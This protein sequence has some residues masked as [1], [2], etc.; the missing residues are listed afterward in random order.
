VKQRTLDVL[1]ETRYEYAAPVELAQHLAYLRPLQDD[2]QHVER[3]ALAIGPEPS[4]QLGS[5]DVFRN[6]RDFFSFY[7]PHSELVVIGQSRVKVTARFG[8]VDLESTDNWNDVEQALRYRAGMKFH[9]EAQFAF[10]SPYV[11]LHREL[12]DYARE[13]FTP[14]RPIGAAAFELMRRIYNDFDYQAASTDISTPLLAAFREK[15]G[16]CQDFAHILISCVRGLGLAARYVSGYLL[17]HSPEDSA[18]YIGA[19][20]SHAWCSVHCPGLGVNDD[21]LD[22]DPTNDMMPAAGHVTLARG[23]DYGDVTPLRGVIRGGGEH[24]LSVAVST[25]MVNP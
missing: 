2:F 3:H 23:R 11:A 20:A 12:T 13:S 10:A 6:H 19:D 25:T 18:N 24:Q 17:T 16:V 1:H 4:W 5:R 22:L 7:T 21:W 9:S 8:G 14:G 15:H